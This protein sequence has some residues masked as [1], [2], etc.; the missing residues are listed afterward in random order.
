MKPL[1]RQSAP[2]RSLGAADPRTRRNPEQFG[3]VA[4]IVAEPLTVKKGKLTLEPA[5]GLADVE[6]QA[7]PALTDSPATAD[8]LRD[9]LVSTVAA[10][11]ANQN[12]L[13]GQINDLKARLRR[14]G[15]MR[16]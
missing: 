6:M 8:A 9:E 11:V 5:P 13:L 2:A 15:I 3:D 12:A 1:A 14:G 7:V 10:L 4:K 16:R